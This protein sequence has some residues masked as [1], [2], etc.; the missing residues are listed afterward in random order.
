MRLWGQMA[1]LLNSLV[2]EEKLKILISYV[3]ND[4]TLLFNT[5]K[6]IINQKY[7]SQTQQNARIFVQYD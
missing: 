6:Y 3:T 7:F 4:G 2:K 5:K 1:H